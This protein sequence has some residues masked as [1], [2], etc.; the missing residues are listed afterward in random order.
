M[1]KKAVF[2]TL[3]EL[4]VVIAIIAILASMLLPALSAARNKTKTISCMNNLKQI[5][6]IGHE[7]NELFDD[8]ILPSVYGPSYWGLV[9]RKA[10]LL[11][12]QPTF[13]KA[14]YLTLT[15]DWMYPKILSCPGESLPFIRT[16]F[17]TEYF[18]RLDDGRTYHFSLN[19]EFCKIISDTKNTEDFFKLAKVKKPADVMNVTEVK[20]TDNVNSY[21]VALYEY[22][23]KVTEVIHRHNGM[24]NTLYFDAH[25]GRHKVPYRPQFYF[26]STSTAL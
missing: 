21:Y 5:A 7:Y 23:D 16:G 24:V 6:Y 26:H 17:E 14:G 19:L 3:I 20:H 22:K 9:L 11:L 15:P 4:L 12:G 10:D 2:F 8:Y 25:V 1:K 18:T 13:Y